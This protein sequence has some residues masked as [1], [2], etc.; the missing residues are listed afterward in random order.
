MTLRPSLR[1]DTSSG[2]LPPHRLPYAPERALAPDASACARER[3]LF[4]FRPSPRSRVRMKSLTCRR[5]APADYAAAGLWIRR[6][7]G[8]EAAISG[9]RALQPANRTCHQ[10]RKGNDERGYR[11]THAAAPRGAVP[12][13]RASGTARAKCRASAEGDSAGGACRGDRGFGT[14]ADRR[15]GGGGG[16]GDCAAI[17]YAEKGQ[18]GAATKADTEDGDERLRS[19]G[20]E[21]PEARKLRRVTPPRPLRV[22]PAQAGI[23]SG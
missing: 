4:R 22:I 2:A 18:A 7:T 1:P 23:H 17:L 21:R 20:G 13:P 5:V 16:P 10:D 15:R 11:P 3:S 19:A 8:I 9:A 12:L 14:D 6:I